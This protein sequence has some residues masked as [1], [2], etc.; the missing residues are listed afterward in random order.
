MVKQFAHKYFSGGSSDKDSACNAGD[1]GPIPGSGRF[2]WRRAWQPAPVFL[3]GEFHGQKNLAGYSLGGHRVR[4]EHDWACSRHTLT[5]WWQG[6]S[7]DV[8]PAAWET[9]CRVWNM[10]GKIM[11]AVFPL[12]DPIT[13]TGLHFPCSLGGPRGWPWL[14]VYFWVLPRFMTG[15]QIRMLWSERELGFLPFLNKTTCGTEVSNVD[16]CQP[17]TDI[18]LWLYGHA[19]VVSD[20][21]VTLWTVACETPPSLEFS[22][23]E[24]WSGVTFPSPGDLPEPGIEPLSPESPALAGGFFI[25]ISAT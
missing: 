20:F 10:S 8:H 21:F 13:I 22:R 25:I 9:L 16:T 18:S 15:W 7:Y 11:K 4:A 14:D 6:C 24:Y 1:P 3:P 5:W 2:R 12:L 23:Q 17:N 19:Q